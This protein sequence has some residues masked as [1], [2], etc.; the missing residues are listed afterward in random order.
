MMERSGERILEMERKLA[1]V[2]A[3]LQAAHARLAMQRGQVKWRLAQVT[4][5]PSTGDRIFRVRFVDGVFPKQEGS[6]SLALTARQDDGKFFVY[7]LLENPNI[8]QGSVVP[9]FEWQGYWYTCC[10]SGE[11]GEPE[12]MAMAEVCDGMTN[13]CCLWSGI[14]HRNNGG[15]NG[16]NLDRCFEV[17][18]LTCQNRDLE[19]NTNYC[20]VM[21]P[22]SGNI[23]EYCGWA[24]DMGQTIDCEGET[25]PLWAIACPCAPCECPANDAKVEV[26]WN[27]VGPACDLPDFEMKCVPYNPITGDVSPGKQGWWGEF[28][29][30]GWYP[31]M[32]QWH[33]LEEG[34]EFQFS[35]PGGGDPIWIQEVLVVFAPN[36][37]N[38]CAPGQIEFWVDYNG[39]HYQV[40]AGNVAL[41]PGGSLGAWEQIRPTTANNCV[42]WM[43]RTYYYGL[44]AEC[45]PGS[46]RPAVQPV[47]I[48][49]L[50]AANTYVTLGCVDGPDVLAPDIDSPFYGD[51]DASVTVINT[52]NCCGISGGFSIDGDFGRDNETVCANVP[53]GDLNNLSLNYNS[54]YWH[55]LGGC[56]DLYASLRSADMEVCDGNALHR[57]LKFIVTWEGREREC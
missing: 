29:V 47:V 35:P 51:E 39:D 17:V 15:Q 48:Y 36:S 28:A 23:P 46:I 33:G 9:A 19:P 5:T 41:D 20:D 56:K 50:P 6:G 53:M 10:G 45:D 12:Q 43:P 34:T 31:R 44:Y 22:C 30:D 25:R 38:A 49:H 54:M 55:V 27:P 18:W 3:E 8:V 37:D 24:R 7:S 42:S 4:N 2:Q 16:C 40:A 1:T 57:I 52:V 32:G 13:S 14:I 21:F 26:K 11:P